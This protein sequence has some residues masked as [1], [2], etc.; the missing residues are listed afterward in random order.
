MS[1]AARLILGTIVTTAIIGATAVLS[2]WPS[3][4]PCSTV[5]SSVRVVNSH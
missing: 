3:C 5:S 4:R 1:R 2:A